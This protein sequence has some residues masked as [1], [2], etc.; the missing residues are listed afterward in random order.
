MTLID[1]QAEDS[2]PMIDPAP[3]MIRILEHVQA[4][5]D[6]Y[7]ALL[8]NKGDPALCAQSFRRFL[9][10]QLRQMV[11]SSRGEADSGKPPTDLSISYIVHAGMGA[12]LWWLEQEQPCPPEQVAAWL[13]QFGQADI[14]VS[15]GLKRLRDEP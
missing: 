15:L 6:F 5:A 4:N 14:Q 9:Q 7:R 10:Q 1:N 13:N 3:G 8:G 12:I 11:R 2:P